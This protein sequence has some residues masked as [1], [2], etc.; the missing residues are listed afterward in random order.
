MKP[1]LR[2][3][4]FFFIIFLF[5]CQAT[6][7]KHIPVKIAV[8]NEATAIPFT[9]FFTTPIHPA[10][11]VGTEFLYK[12]EVRFRFYQTAN[13]GYIYHNNLYQGFYLNSEAGYDYQ[14]TFG[15]VIK[16]LLG[17]GYLHTF[18]TQEEYQFEN[19]DYVH[20]REW[21]N[22]RLMAVLSFGLGYKLQKSKS[23]SPE[24]FV[25]YKSW[26]EFPYSPGFIPV[27]THI[28]LEV[29]ARFYI[30]VRRNEKK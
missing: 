10:I 11:E 16:A 19:G 26:I 23:A 7:Q 14:F 3:T 15:L 9:R 22:P 20:G 1:F 28:N 12:Q 25:L 24:I 29:G 18:T 8:S 27:M 4:V 6:A 13:I 2:H 21:G 5:T 17:V 30:H